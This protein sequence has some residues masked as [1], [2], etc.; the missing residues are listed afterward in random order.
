MLSKDYFTPK[1]LLITSTKDNYK[2]YLHGS[3]IGP[4]ASNFFFLIYEFPS[5]LPFVTSLSRQIF[6]KLEVF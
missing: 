5:Y 6:P 4:G 2:F 1:S 3:C